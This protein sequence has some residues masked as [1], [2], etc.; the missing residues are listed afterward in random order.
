MSASKLLKY[1]DPSASPEIRVQDLLGR[2]TLP[3]KI[4][5]MTGVWNLKRETLTHKSGQFDIEKAK[6]YYGEGHGLGQFGRP[7]D[8]GK[9]GEST[10]EKGLNARHTAQLTNDIQQFFKEHSRL[11]IPVMF[12]D[13]CLHGLAG[14]GASSFPQPIALGATFN[15]LL[16][17]KLYAIAAKEAR[18]RGIHQALTPVLDVAREPRWGRVEETFGEDPHLVAQLGIAAVKGL[19]GAA[20]FEDQEK[21]IATLKHFVAHSQPESGMNCGP[22]NISER[23][24]R[25]VFLKPFKEAVEN[26]KAISVMAAYNEIDGVPCHA[27]EWLLKEILCKE[28]GFKGFIVSDYYAITE[29]HE[30]P[31]T[32]SHRVANSKATAAILALKAGVN[33][34][35]PEPDCYPNITQL[36]KDGSI[37]E[38]I[39][40]ELLRP[41]LYWKFKM[42]LFENSYVDPE[43]AARISECQAHIQ[44]CRKAAQEAI[45]LLKNDENILPLNPSKKQSIALVG[46]NADCHLLGGY[47]G[48]PGKTSSILDGFQASA[49]KHGFELIYSPGCQISQGGAWEVDEVIIPTPEQNQLLID[50]AIKDTGAADVIVVALGGNTQTAREAWTNTHMGDRSDLKLFGQQQALFDALKSTGKPIVVL[51]VHGRPLAIPEIAEKADAIVDCWYLGQEGGHAV[52]DIMFGDCNPS[53]KLPISIPRSIGQLPIFYN[54]KPSARRGYILDDATPLFSFGY[55]LSYT[56]FQL[57]EISMGIPILTKGESTYV[58]VKISNIGDYAGMEVI[59]MYVRDCYSSVTRPVKELKGFL[60]IYLEPG[61]SETIQI[62]IDNKSLEFY[63]MDMNLT[64]EA[65]IF[66][67]MIGTSSRDIDLQKFELEVID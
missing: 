6:K 39:L 54:Y 20:I 15:P 44:L 27:N 53:G 66:E 46:P 9:D 34:E 52:A 7:C 40:D 17:E 64:I 37:Q 55:G 56:Q 45:I 58:S 10:H 23:V 19:Q 30:R 50:Q 62:P 3:E 51:L 26:A 24:L 14:K 32:H 36:V 61:A 25:E 12:H 28:W 29:L 49:D 1:R 59:Q 48:A 35:L 18:S 65:G 42:G 22:V 63:N 43:E 47:S 31:E 11:G 33:V 13:E 67:I 60:K 38:S 41:V 2:M 5:Q 8:G 16:I 21:V 57:S 4:A